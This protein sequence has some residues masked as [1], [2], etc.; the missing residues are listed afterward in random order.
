MAIEVEEKKCIATKRDVGKS[1]H[2]I[3]EVDI[4]IL[5]TALPGNKQQK[6]DRGHASTPQAPR[7]HGDE[8]NE[9]VGARKPLRYRLQAPKRA[10]GCP[11]SLQEGHGCAPEF[12]G[13]R[14]SDALPIRILRGGVL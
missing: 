10:K 13:L 1:N 2:T 9:S 8:Y 6:G 5:C 3:V 4:A 7:P 12:A 11:S 14:W